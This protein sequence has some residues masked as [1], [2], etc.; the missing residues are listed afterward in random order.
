M[1]TLIAAIDN[2][3][4]SDVEQHDGHDDTDDDEQGGGDRLIHEVSA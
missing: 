3:G 2:G 4:V 1:E